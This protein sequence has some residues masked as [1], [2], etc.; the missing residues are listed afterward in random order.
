ML[1]DLAVE[2][3]RRRY[4]YLGLSKV[5]IRCTYFIF[6]RGNKSWPNPELLSIKYSISTIPPPSLQSLLPLSTS[7]TPLL[8]SSTALSTSSSSLH[9]H[10][11][12]LFSFC[13]SFFNVNVVPIN[14]LVILRFLSSDGHQ[15]AATPPPP[16]ILEVNNFCSKTVG[17]CDV[18]LL[19]Q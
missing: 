19:K 9:H 2:I 6:C 3:S 1:E 14:Y 13:N 15:G 18:I 8:S 11:Y 17:K 12:N 16:N 5:I 7:S 4:I 10:A